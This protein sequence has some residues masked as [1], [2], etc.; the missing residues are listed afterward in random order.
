MKAAGTS[1]TS[2]TAMAIRKNSLNSVVPASTSQT[3]YWTNL[4]FN[5][6]TV[7]LLS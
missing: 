6:A 7:S 1:A 2:D 5:S 3:W 4:S